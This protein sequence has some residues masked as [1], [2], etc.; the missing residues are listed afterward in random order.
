[1]TESAYGVIAPKFGLPSAEAVQQLFMNFVPMARL[2]SADDVA[3]A[4]L[5][6]ASDESLYVT[7]S[8]LMVDGGMSLQ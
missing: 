5:Y 2:G 8:S 6:L 4:A 3:H 1:M 7:G